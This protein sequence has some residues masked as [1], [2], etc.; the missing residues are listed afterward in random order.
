MSSSTTFQSFG[1]RRGGEN[2]EGRLK[3][4]LLSINLGFPLAPRSF[5]LVSSLQ[6]EPNCAVL[7]QPRKYKVSN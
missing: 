4:G 5:I 2:G 1:P 7:G 3:A 6:S